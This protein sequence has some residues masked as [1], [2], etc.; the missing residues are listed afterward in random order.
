MHNLKGKRVLVGGGAGFVGSALVRGLL[1]DEVNVVVYDN[2][3]HD[4]LENLREVQ[5]RIKIVSGDALD[6]WRISDTFIPIRVRRI[7]RTREVHPN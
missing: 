7:Q 1:E 4:T 3:L 6:P 2:F 5:D